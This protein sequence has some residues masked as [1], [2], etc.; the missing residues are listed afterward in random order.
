MKPT[1]KKT[2]EFMKRSKGWLLLA[3]IGFGAL[4][5]AFRNSSIGRST[6]SNPR[7]QLLTELGKVL[8]DLHYT[9]K[10]IDDQFSK[11]MFSR[12]LDQMDGDKTLFLK[13]DI[14]SL[15]VFETSLDNEIHGSPIAFVPAVSSLYDR[16]MAEAAIIYK[17]LLKNPF[18]FS[19]NETFEIDG[20]KLAWAKNEEERK[21]RWRKKML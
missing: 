12:Y 13:K 14:D 10:V 11:M 8:E 21:D 1:M 6:S 5:F 3:L 20:E 18:S 17:E 4:F 15:K 7:Q 19:A 2:I 16:R 9:P